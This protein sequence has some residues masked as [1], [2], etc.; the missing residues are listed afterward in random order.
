MSE[1]LVVAWA[2]VA[3]V[4]WRVTAILLAAFVFPLWALAGVVVHVVLNRR[5]PSTRSAVFCQSVAGELRTG[6]SLRVAIAEA[7]RSVEAVAISRALDSGS[8][9]S[10][11]VPEMKTEF[12]E[13]GREIGALVTAVSETGSAAAPL[14]QELGDLALAQ[15]ETT[16]EIKVAAS[17]ARASATVLVGLP[18]LYI[19]YQLSTGAIGG[20]LGDPAQQGI[21]LVGMGLAG[22]GLAVSFFLVRRAL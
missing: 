19:G 9:L 22:A 17:P 7:A 15:V 10:E 14:F 21:A 16:E 13:I 4:D 6:A 18:V 12:P 20:L 2:L 5:P 8:L 11:I 3:G 1:W